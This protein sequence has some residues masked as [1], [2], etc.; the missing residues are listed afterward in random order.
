MP[1]I[2]AAYQAHQRKRWMRPNAHLFIRPDWRRF[3]RP[4]HR[5]DHL[6]AQYERKY[7]PNQPRMPAGSREGG[8]WT[9]KPS[10]GTVSEGQT[11]ELSAASRGKGHHYVP[12]AVFEKKGLSE[13]A[14]AVF[15]KATT[16]PLLDTRSNKWD[17]E[18]RI[19]SKAV[20]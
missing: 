10:P 15:E 16:G 19:Y 13:E 6:F 7:S 5:E 14:K 12:R 2:D 8:Q 18:H 3:V 11:V 17:Q 4:A 20:D 9:D 1:P